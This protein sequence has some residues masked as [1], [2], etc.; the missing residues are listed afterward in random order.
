MIPS[1]ASSPLQLILAAPAAS[2]ARR[3]NY[4]YAS[5]QELAAG[6]HQNDLRFREEA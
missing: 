1:H 5:S 4:G 6:T 2:F 3:R